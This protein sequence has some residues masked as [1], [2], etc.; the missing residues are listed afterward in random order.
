MSISKKTQVTVQN[1]GLQF[2]STIQAGNHSWIADEPIDAGG[3]NAG[4]SPHELLAGALGSCTAI[5]LNMYASRKKW[6]LTGIR[7]HVSILREVV[8][9]VQETRINQQVEL[10]GPLDE[11]QR[12]RL[13]EIAAKCPVHK[14][15]KSA[16]SIETI[17]FPVE[18]K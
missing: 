13:M 7:I 6:Q 9:G 8:N 17:L 5:T 16:I 11:M 15:M 2:S 18:V 4:P 10:I 3:L 14:T 1:D 12:I